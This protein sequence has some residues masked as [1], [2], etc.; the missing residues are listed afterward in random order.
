MASE[1]DLE[2]QWPVALF[3]YISFTLLVVV[4]Y[5]RKELHVAVFD[6]SALGRSSP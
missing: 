2:I 5:S 1:A 4:S 6:R 3:T